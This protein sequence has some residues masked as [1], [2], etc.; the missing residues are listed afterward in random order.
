LAA[1]PFLSG[2]I[3]KDYSRPDS[4]VFLSSHYITALQHADTP[5]AHRTSSA[6]ARGARVTDDGCTP[7]FKLLEI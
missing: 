2:I 4:G 6:T 1:K 7:D 3:P 5:P